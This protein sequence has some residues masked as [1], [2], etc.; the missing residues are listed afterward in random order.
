MTVEQGL[1]NI[2]KHGIVLN[3]NKNGDIDYAP[4]HLLTRNM[5]LFLLE[6]KRAVVDFLKNELP[7]SQ[8]KH[9]EKMGQILNAWTQYNNISGLGDKAA[10]IE[11]L[12]SLDI[13]QLGIVQAEMELLADVWN[14]WNQDRTKPLLVAFWLKDGAAFSDNTHLFEDGD[15]KEAQDYLNKMR[16]PL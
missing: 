4:S 7:D 5:L 1:N 14:L 13:E 6:H 8:G 15:I 10:L 11:S 3:I 2:R 12:K 16:P 9:F